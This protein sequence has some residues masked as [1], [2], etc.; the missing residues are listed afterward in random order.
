ML[1]EVGN[2][3]QIGESAQPKELFIIE[4]INEMQLRI[5]TDEEIE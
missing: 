4:I 3:Q 2:S 1:L 5:N